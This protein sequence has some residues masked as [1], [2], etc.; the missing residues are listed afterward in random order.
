MSTGADCQPTRRLLQALVELILSAQQQQ[1]RTTTTITTTVVHC[2][3][4]PSLSQVSA[5]L[6]NV[7]IDSFDSLFNSY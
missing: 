4:Q 3:V 1:Q 7:A 2:Y 5:N 6:V